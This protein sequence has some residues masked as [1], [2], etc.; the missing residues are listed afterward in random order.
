MKRHFLILLFLFIVLSNSF[1]KETLNNY[2]I[3]TTINKS[4]DGTITADIYGCIEEVNM[5]GVISL[6]DGELL[7]RLYNSNGLTVFTKILSTPVSLT[8]HDTI[9]AEPGGWRLTYKSNEGGREL[10]N[11]FGSVSF[12]RYGV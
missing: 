6:S 10:H 9:F 3:D 2:N 4:S 12:S 1:K 8:I 5:H 7:I 11:L